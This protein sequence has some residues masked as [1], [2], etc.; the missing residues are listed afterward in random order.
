[1]VRLAWLAHS[2]WQATRVC[3]EAQAWTILETLDP[4]STRVDI[5]HPELMIRLAEKNIQKTWIAT[6]PDL[7]A[8]CPGPGKS[9]LAYQCL[10]ASLSYPQIPLIIDADAL[11]LISES[12]ELLEQLRER[13]TTY[14]GLTTLTP[15]PGEAAKLLK[16]TTEQVQSNRLKAIQQ[17]VELTQS[18]IVLKGQHTLIASPQH[19]PVQCMAGT[20]CIGTRGMGD[21]LTGSIAAIAG[22][23]VRH[24]LD[25]WEANGIAVEFHARAADSLID[26][27]IC[28]I[29]PTPSETILEM[30]SLSNKLP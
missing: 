9:E 6:Q 23:G 22:Q 5:H 4:A 17:L 30:R 1:M 28:P 16:T 14:P 27:G 3:I 7:I 11:N 19:P 21:V 25:L 12:P 24:H 20:P 2:Y 13:N 15:H 10:C 26:K 18:I 29:G 8:I